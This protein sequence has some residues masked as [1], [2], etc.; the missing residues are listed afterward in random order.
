MSTARCI[1]WTVKSLWG[2]TK[3]SFAIKL[4]DEPERVSVRFTRTRASI[5]YD[6]TPI[7]SL[8]YDGIGIPSR[9]FDG[10]GVPSYEVANNPG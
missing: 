7:P 6:G 3:D 8:K 4:P 2:V 1:N 9:Q 10:I 5:L